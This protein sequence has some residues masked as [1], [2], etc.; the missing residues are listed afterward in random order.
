[1]LVVCFLVLV[2]W[3]VFFS[4]IRYKIGR[5]LVYTAVCRDYHFLC[6]FSVWQRN[7]LPMPQS[8]QSNQTYFVAVCRSHTV[9][10]RVVESYVKGIKRG[11]LFCVSCK[12]LEVTVP[13]L[14]QRH[15]VF[16]SVCCIECFFS[17]V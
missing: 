14:I 15:F 1:M 7:S 2:V 8:S 16:P 10:V 17:S 4:A 9:R 12:I 11:V 3:S 6:S 13:L 5:F